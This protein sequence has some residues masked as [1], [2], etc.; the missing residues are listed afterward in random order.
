MRQGK[1]DRASSLASTPGMTLAAMPPLTQQGDFQHQSGG[2]GK[3]RSVPGEYLRLENDCAQGVP[4]SVIR[5]SARQDRKSATLAL[6]VNRLTRATS[7]I[8]FLIS[9][10][11]RILIDPSTRSIRTGPPFSRPTSRR[12]WAGRLSLPAALTRPRRLGRSGNICF[13]ATFCTLACVDFRPSLDGSLPGRCLARRYAGA[14]GH[15]GGAARRRAVR[16]PPCAPTPPSRSGS[17]T[18]PR[19]RF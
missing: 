3:P 11:V 2:E 5:S 14:P 18:T 6:S 4:A 7:L 12:R 8:L 17:P 9:L 13:D 10:M 15:P 19:P 16:S 1:C